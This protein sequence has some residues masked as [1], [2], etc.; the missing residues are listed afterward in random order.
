MILLD[1][2]IVIY[3][4]HP[5]NKFQLLREFLLES[6]H[7]VSLASYVE[8]LGFHRLKE[9][10]HRSFAVFFDSVPI[11]PITSEIAEHAVRLRQ[12][13]KMSLGDALIAATAIVENITLVTNN[14]KDFKWIT[15]LTIIDPFEDT[16][17]SQD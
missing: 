1:S 4:G 16:A 8:V 11:I 17:S 9:D 10:D 14:T 5:D 12:Q 15:S 2:N 6:E 7:C 3:S 13:R